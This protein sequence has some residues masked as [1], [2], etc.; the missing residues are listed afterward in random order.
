MAWADA[1]L[2]PS[3][4]S[5]IEGYI[6]TQKWLSTE[7]IEFLTSF[8]DPKQPPSPQELKS[9]K[10]TI[11]ESSLEM[12]DNLAEIGIKLSNLKGSDTPE[13]VRESLRE[14]EDMLG[15]ASSE[16]TYHLRA[17]KPNTITE[18]LT[19]KRSF[20]VQ[21]M[22]S[23]LDGSDHEII[24]KVKKVLSDPV[25]TYVDPDN[26]NTYREQ[27]LTWCRLLADQGFGSMAFPKE[28]GGEADMKKYFAIMETLS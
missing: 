6:R 10:K 11:N 14:I 7:E 19:S 5:A 27:V 2:L 23:L 28:Y 16:A 4:I 26:L 18:Q 20:D 24:N 15:I 3:E 12:K 21:K 1:V 8:L 17:N 9:W 13:E 25:F 22:T